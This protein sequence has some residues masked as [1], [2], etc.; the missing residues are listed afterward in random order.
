M[1]TLTTILVILLFTLFVI[2]T[3]QTP[4]IQIGRIIPYTHNTKRKTNSFQNIYHLMYFGGFVST[5]F[6]DFF[7]SRQNSSKRFELFNNRV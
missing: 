4:P 3:A 2:T 7:N 6:V 1:K 5:I